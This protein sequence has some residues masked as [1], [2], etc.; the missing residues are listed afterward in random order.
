MPTKTS[1]SECR[2]SSIRDQ[3]TK[4]PK[5]NKTILMGTF[6]GKNRKE[7]KKQ[8]LVCIDTLNFLFKIAEKTICNKKAKTGI[9]TLKGNR[10]PTN[11]KAKSPKTGI[12]NQ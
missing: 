2:L 9:I 4:K 12:K 7:N 5:Q 10:K 8:K 3:A 1:F 11:T 6:N